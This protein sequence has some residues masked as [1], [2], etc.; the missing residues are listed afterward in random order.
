M[1]TTIRTFILLSEKK[2]HDQLYQNLKSKHKDNWIHIFKKEDFTYDN[3]IDINPDFI[4]IPHWS[5]IIPADIYTNFRCVIFHMTDLPYGRGGSP[6]QNLILRGH[7]ETQISALRCVAELDAGPIYM[8]RPL[9]LEGSASDIFLRAAEEIEYMI[10]EIVSVEPIPQPQEG[11][12]IIFRRR[13]PEQSNLSETNFSTLYD[14]FNFIRMLDAD[15]YPKAYFDLSEFRVELSRV[16]FEQG[17]LVGNFEIRPKT[18]EK[19]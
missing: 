19:S 4:F 5:Y 14:F 18:S 3:I 11:E 13:T 9:S 15:G 6:L 17:K 8:K 7:E 12:P 1:G 16:Q 10:E 2:W